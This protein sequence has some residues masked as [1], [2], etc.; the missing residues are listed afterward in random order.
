MQIGN[1]MWLTG[2]RCALRL[3]LLLVQGMIAS[4]A[5]FSMRRVARLNVADK[6]LYRHVAEVRVGVQHDKVLHHLVEGLFFALEEAGFDGAQR[7]LIKLPDVERCR[8]EQTLVQFSLLVVD[9][10]GSRS[11]RERPSDPS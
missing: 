5:L 3:L 9:L 1:M 4:F 6:L 2:V 10:I 11:G 7:L 8:F